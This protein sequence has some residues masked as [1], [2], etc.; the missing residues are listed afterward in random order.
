MIGH[1]LIIIKQPECFPKSHG[2]PKSMY[3]LTYNKPARKKTLTVRK[4][5]EYVEI[6]LKSTTN[7][8]PNLIFSGKKSDINTSEDVFTFYFQSSTFPGKFC[9]F[10]ISILLLPTIC[11]NL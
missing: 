1:H 2:H 9:V 6:S 4:T 8:I 11:Y 5:K 3:K 7:M 10:D